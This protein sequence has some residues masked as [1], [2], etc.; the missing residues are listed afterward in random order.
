MTEN[1][2]QHYPVAVDLFCGAGGLSYG[3][4]KAGVKVAYGVDL[5][6][7]CRHALEANSSARFYHEDVAKLSCETVHSMFGNA[8][9][10]LLAGCAPCQPFSTYS[11]SRKSSDDR[12]N[13]L[14]HFQRIVEGVLPEL[15]TMENVSGL[16]KREVWRDF[17]LTLNDLG[18]S[19]SWRIV[20][21][22]KFGI[23]QTRKRLV[24]VAS[25][26]GKISFFDPEEPEIVTVREAIGGLPKIA[27]GQKC[28]RDKLH[29]SSVLSELNLDRIRASVPGGTW[30]DWPSELRAECH[31]RSSGKSY[32]SVY[33][34]MEWDKPAPTMTTQC[35]GFGNGR[36]GHPEQDRAISLRE[37]AII[38]SFPS[39]YE[40]WSDNEEFSFKHAGTL[41]GN[42]VPP[43]LGEAIGNCMVEHA[44]QHF[45]A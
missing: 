33:G 39:S 36:F 4:C 5:D 13:L 24:L 23:P 25:L 8:K 16:S 11:Q 43:K 19:V 15:V 7:K 44:T 21:C 35:Y 12:W 2:I 42:A 34:R 10:R 20:D 18:Y 30:R 1:D 17:V 45:G 14:L 40:F 26:L 32:P 38:Q 9:V 27:A 29:T 28:S 37:A 22:A 3:L 31:K 6:P 41:I